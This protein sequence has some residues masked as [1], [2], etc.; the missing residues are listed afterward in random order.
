MSVTETAHKWYR[1]PP[2]LTGEQIRDE[3]ERH[4]RW[5][6]EKADQLRRRRQQ[7]KIVL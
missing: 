2:R 4:E 5:R 6:L 3:I 1:D 7:V